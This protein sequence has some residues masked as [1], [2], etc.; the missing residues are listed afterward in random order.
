MKQTELTESPAS[1]SSAKEVL[2]TVPK[3]GDA[4]SAL[5]GVV[6]GA[7]VLAA[8]FLL[9]GKIHVLPKGGG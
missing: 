6:V 8:G 9:T 3:E 5:A 7:A 1:L 4:L 2:K